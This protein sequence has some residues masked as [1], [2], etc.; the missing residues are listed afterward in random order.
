MSLASLIHIW[1]VYQGALPNLVLTLVSDKIGNLKGPNECNSTGMLSKLS[2][3]I[4]NLRFYDS[5]YMPAIK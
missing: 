5:E 1:A 3:F 2:N 4:Y